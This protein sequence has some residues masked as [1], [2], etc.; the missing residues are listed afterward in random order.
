MGR[1]SSVDK[2]KKEVLS[3]KR[4]A[5]ESATAEA[6]SESSKVR[7]VDDKGSLGSDAGSTDKKKSDNTLQEE[8][9]ALAQAEIWMAIAAQSKQE[10]RTEAK[11][12]S[13]AA[14]WA[15]SRSLVALNANEHIPSNESNQ[16]ERQK[17]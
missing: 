8:Q 3:E 5:G 13:D 4:K 15:I 17:K 2:K 10:S 1:F 16:A 7:K 12:A 11:G 9:D 6:E 14:D